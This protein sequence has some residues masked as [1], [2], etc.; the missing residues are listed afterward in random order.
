MSRSEVTFDRE[1]GVFEDD[2]GV[3]EE[4]GEFG[5]RG[6]AGVGVVDVGDEEVVE[7][8]EE[9]AVDLFAADDVDVGI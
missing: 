9:G 7:V 6:I 4:V 3:R 1:V 5:K 8:R 2:F